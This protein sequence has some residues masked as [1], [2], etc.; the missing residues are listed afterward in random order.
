MAV[1]WKVLYRKVNMQP[2]NK[3]SVIRQKGEFF[4][5]VSGGKKCSFLEKFGMLCFLETPVLRFALLPYYRQIIASCII[6]VK[7]FMRRLIWVCK[8]MHSTQNVSFALNLF[9]FFLFFFCST[10]IL[11]FFFLYSAFHVEIK[12]REY[13]HGTSTNIKIV[14]MELQWSRKYKF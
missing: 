2:S 13:F 4:V 1:L 11:V 9:S 5:C 6:K 8:K 7:N 3:L 12:L 10:W 14:K